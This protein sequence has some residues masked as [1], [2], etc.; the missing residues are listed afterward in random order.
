MF[1]GLFFLPVAFVLFTN[2]SGGIGL[3]HL[4]SK[5]ENLIQW[6]ADFLIYQPRCPHFKALIL[7]ILTCLKVVCSAAL[8]YFWPNHYHLN[9]C[10]QHL[11]RFTKRHSLLL[12]KS[13]QKGTCQGVA[14]RYEL[15]HTSLHAAGFIR[16]HPWLICGSVSCFSVS[17]DSQRELS[18]ILQRLLPLWC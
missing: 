13:Y 5:T 17:P 1:S 10:V 7:T 9:A 11:L 12:N 2:S 3:L 6:S 18:Q 16:P 14:P 8:E 4:E 15:L